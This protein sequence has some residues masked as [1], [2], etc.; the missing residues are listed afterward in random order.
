LYDN[1]LFLIPFFSSLLKKRE[2]EKESKVAK[3]DLEFTH[4]GVLIKENDNTYWMYLSYM[5]L[6][7]LI[8]IL[9]NLGI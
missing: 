2:L 7:L 4:F 1:W 5:S 8:L 3:I 6:L 9:G